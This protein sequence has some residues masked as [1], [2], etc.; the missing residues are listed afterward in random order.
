M[1]RVHKYVPQAS[2]LVFMEATSSLDRALL[3]YLAL[4]GSAAGAIP[5]RVLLFLMSQLLLL[6]LAFFLLK[7]IMP[8][9]AFY[10]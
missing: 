4:A 9:G 5:L 10:G 3:I 7:S 2:E 8:S 1:A 6:L